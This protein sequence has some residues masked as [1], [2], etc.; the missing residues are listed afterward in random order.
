MSFYHVHNRKSQ[1]IF[2]LR[3][4]PQAQQGRAAGTAQRLKVGDPPPA[5]FG[6]SSAVGYPLRGKFLVLLKGPWLLINLLLQTKL[7]LQARC[8]R[9]NLRKEGLCF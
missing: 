4:I 9:K 1:T 8:W 7:P 5:D 2:L 3:W 6:S